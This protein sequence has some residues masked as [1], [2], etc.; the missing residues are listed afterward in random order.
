MM[1]IESAKDLE[2]ISENYSKKLYYP[3]TV[4]VNVGIASCGIAAGAQASIEKAAKEFPA[5]TVLALT[6]PVVSVSANAS[7]WLKYS[8]KGSL[9]F[10]IKI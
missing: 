2:V 5:T 9:G 1:K 8:R 4:K 3:E 10:F 7:L 6:R